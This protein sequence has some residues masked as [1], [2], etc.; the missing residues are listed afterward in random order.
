MI[1]PAVPYGFSPARLRLL[2]VFRNHPDRPLSISL[3]KKET[4]FSAKQLDGILASLAKMGFGFG[5]LPAKGVRLFSKPDLFFPELILSGLATRK[6]GKTLYGF[7]K[8]GST[9]DRALLL[10]EK[11]A[12]EGTLVTTEEQ[13]KGRGRR[14]RTW[15]SAA[16]KSL[17]FSLILRPSLAPD[18]AAE[19]TLAA[20]VAVVLTLQEWK[21]QARIKW[22]N[23]I[24]LGG[25]KAGGILNETRVKQAK[26]TFAVIGI[27]IN[28]NQSAEDFPREI[29]ATATSLLRH[30]GKKAD[31]VLFLQRLLVQLETVLGWV[32]RRQFHRVL[33]EWR[34]RSILSNRQVRITQPG[35]IFFAQA[36]DVDEKGALL[37]RNDWGMV[38]RVLA[39]DVELLRISNRRVPRRKIKTKRGL[40]DLGD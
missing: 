31:R 22:P 35:R 32:E 27:G 9:N 21:V 26:M 33:A 25:K 40:H 8:L 34:K 15:S 18:E 24:F 29:K 19:L 13:T 5:F 6:I 3:L 30:S 2:D 23:D 28:L 10:G 1:P 38:E 17:A 39:G 20:A 7:R 37:V 16:G 12:P 36:L 14:G 4:G 11:G